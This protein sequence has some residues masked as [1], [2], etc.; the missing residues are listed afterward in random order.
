[1][2][3]IAVPVLS[4]NYVWIAGQTP[5]AD[6]VIVV[7]PGAA[8]P[9][10][11]YLSTQDLNVAAYFITHHHG[12]HTG[13][14]AKLVAKWP[15][16]VYA[17]AD[18]TQRIGH[19]DH[20]VR[21][22]DRVSITALGAEF[23]VISVPGHTLGHIAFHGAGVL[24]SGDALFRGGCGRVFEGT[25]E[26]M[27]AGLARLRALPDSTAVYAGHEYTQKNLEF[28][29]RV[30][31][32]NADIHALREVVATRRSRGEPTLPGQ[33]AEE[34]QINPFLRWDQPV[35]A[36]AAAERDGVDHQDG[37][38]VFASIRRWKDAS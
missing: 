16:P 35:V 12:D 7:D 37:D 27:R 5:D 29:A 18:E 4:D 14:L 31:P 26:Q 32:N 1:M 17:P 6:A 9:V 38:A 2:H 24:F 19:V 8:Q 11:D 22:N 28:A 3:V 20:P 34:R 36:A 25:F 15:A 21:H 13:G 30:E 10:A 33:L 23:E